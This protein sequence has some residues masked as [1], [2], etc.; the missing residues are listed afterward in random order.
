MNSS[1]RGRKRINDIKH[2]Q[3]RTH[4]HGVSVEL[5]HLIVA[6]SHHI[7]NS[8]AS[9]IVATFVSEN[10]G[11]TGTN[12]RTVKC[13]VWI[14]EE[15]SNIGRSVPAFLGDEEYKTTEPWDQQIIEQRQQLMTSL[16]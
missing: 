3:T 9:F 14:S 10:L 16:G 5:N 6:V 7:V 15:T 1:G 12:P 8:S 13:L 4:A 11:K 2:I